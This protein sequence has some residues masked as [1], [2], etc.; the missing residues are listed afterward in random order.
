[1][2]EPGSDA[3]TGRHHLGQLPAHPGHFPSVVGPASSIIHLNEMKEIDL[4]YKYLINT[5]SQFIENLREEE[6]VVIQD[7]YDDIVFEGNGVDLKSPPV[8]FYELGYLKTIT[9]DGNTSTIYCTD[10][11]AEQTSHSHEQ[12]DDSLSLFLVS[13]KSVD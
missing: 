5:K 6:H 1:M 13:S 9:D 8:D 4:A 7:I 3:G 2:G 12:H 11:P 10:L